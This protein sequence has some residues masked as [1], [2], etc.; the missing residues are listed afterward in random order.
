MLDTIK[1]VL[2]VSSQYK[3]DISRLRSLSGL[4]LSAIEIAIE[5]YPF[6]L[7]QLIDF[8]SLFNRFPNEAEV[9]EF[10]IA[11]IDNFI[12][13]IRRMGLPYY[14]KMCDPNYER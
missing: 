10:G 5:T 3:V 1:F 8:Y 9:K 6:S 4:S 12:S 13:S 14:E 7:K 2:K 11:G